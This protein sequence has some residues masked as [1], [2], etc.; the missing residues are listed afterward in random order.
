MYKIFF[1]K[2]TREISEEMD[3]EELIS[4]STPSA[5]GMFFMKIMYSN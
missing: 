3:E 1:R 2:V 5:V 4:I